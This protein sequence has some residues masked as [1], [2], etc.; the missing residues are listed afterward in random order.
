YNM[1]DLVNLGM[2]SRQ[3]KELLEFM[4]KGCASVVFCGK[5]AAGK[6]TLLRAFIDTMPEMERVL[7]AESDTEIYPSKPYCIQHK[8]KK[9]NEGGIVVTLSD[10][11]RDGLTMS[12]DTYVIGEIVGSEAWEFIKAS[13]SGHRCSGTV[14]AENAK[15][16]F[17]RLM[18]LARGDSNA[19]SE[20]T[21]LQMAAEGIDAV[22]YLKNFKVDEILEVTGF[23]DKND[24]VGTRFLY[25]RQAGERVQPPSDRLMSKGG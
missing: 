2:M 25:K 11:V 23:D 18:A 10:L 6:T 20:K 8:I 22:V 1:N 15:A 12:L 21:I 24:L 5:G 9:K 4:A 7:I 17:A 3:V 16:V 13:F 19:Y 14:H